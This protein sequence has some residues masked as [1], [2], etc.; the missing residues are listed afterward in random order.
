MFWKF[1][2]CIHQLLKG[3]KGKNYWHGIF[4][5]AKVFEFSV[6][7][8]ETWVVYEFLLVGTIFGY[9]FIFESL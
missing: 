8:F 9:L 2:D 5:V 6:W 3:E 7:L 1:T 4:A